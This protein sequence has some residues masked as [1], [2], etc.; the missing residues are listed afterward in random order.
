MPRH[1]STAGSSST[2]S[3]RSIVGTAPSQPAVLPVPRP[4]TSARRGWG[5]RIAPTQAGHHLRAGVAAGAAVGLAVDDEGVVVG[6]DRAPRCSRGRPLPDEVRRARCIQPRS[7]RCGFEAPR[8]RPAP[9]PAVPPGGG[10]PEGEDAQAI[11]TSATAAARQRPRD[12]RDR[13]DERR[14]AEQREQH[15][16]QP[17]AAGRGEQREQAEAAG[18]RAGDRAERVP[19]IGEA[20]VRARRPLRP[21]PRSAISSGNCTPAMNAG[22]ED[23]DA[24]R[25]S[26]RGR[27]RK[28]ERAERRGGSSPAPPADRRAR[29]GARSRRA[30]SEQV[31]AKPPAVARARPLQN[32]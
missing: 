28:A 14:D 6:V 4:I 30:S 3:T 19:G 20:D 24:S 23:H 9:M 12:A 18:E 22:R 7:W 1:S 29:R 8:A 17:P 32:E 21:L 11:A 26:S 25:A 13:V 15:D 31:R 10:R 16:D 2:T 27:G 5:W